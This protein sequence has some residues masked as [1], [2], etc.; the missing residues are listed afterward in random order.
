M[1]VQPADRPV[2]FDVAR[3]DIPP[4]F[5]ARQSQAAGPADAPRFDAASL[6]GKEG[7]TQ[8]DIRQDSLGD[9]YLVATLAAVAQQ[10]PD[11]IRDAISFNAETGSYS[12]RLFDSNG[13]ARSF[14][15]TQADVADNIAR[16][17]GSTADNSGTDQ[18]IWPAVME[19]AYAKMLDSDHANGIEEGYTDL[20]DGGWPQ[21]A[22]QA[23]TGDRGSETRFSQGMFEGRGAALDRLA[24]Q[25][26][27]ALGNDRPVTLW[28]VPENRSMW[29]RITGGQGR[30]D[31][32]V[33]NH[34]YS[35]ESIR[36]DANGE[37]QV[38]LRNPWATNA[39][40]EGGNVQ[41][42]LITVPLSTLV[43]TGGLQAF[44]MG[45]AGR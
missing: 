31:G 19:V 20:S 2:A 12:V 30:Q 17:G 15:V 41:G 26:D 32:L 21:D 42:P 9:C 43:E 44:T 28:S 4:P 45:P 22:M 6:W 13:R 7:P 8:A 39:G 33:D 34:V 14:E 40:V 1:Y 36:R 18:R 25:V 29:D 11:R 10:Q 3:L 37:W 35:V 24:G 5:Q 16:R 23:I 27:A 38:T